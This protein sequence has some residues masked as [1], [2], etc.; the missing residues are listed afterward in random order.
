VVLH[1]Q[2]L[3]PMVPQT[4]GD[5]VRT[6]VGA[7]RHASAPARLAAAARRRQ[8][9]QDH[10]R[11]IA[12]GVGAQIDAGGV[13]APAAVCARAPVGIACAASSNTNR[14]RGELARK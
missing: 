4:G 7:A 14:A 6:V 12:S 5:G 3:A 9:L 13:V 2:A 8:R 1:R 11:E 10:A